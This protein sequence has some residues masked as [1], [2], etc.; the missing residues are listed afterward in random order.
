MLRSRVAW[1]ASA[2]VAAVAGYV[3]CVEACGWA[4]G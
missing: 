2:A 1:T 4:Y 3:D